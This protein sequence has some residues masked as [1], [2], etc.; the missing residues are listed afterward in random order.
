MPEFQKEQVSPNNAEVV[1][2]SECTK[3]P[4]A[5]AGTSEV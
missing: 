2:L 1:A 4:Q 5:G 3:R